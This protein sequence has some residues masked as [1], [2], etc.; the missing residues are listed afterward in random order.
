MRYRTLTFVAAVAAALSLLPGQ[1]IAQSLNAKPAKTATEAWTAPRTV[2]GRP[3]PVSYT[4]LDVY[5][6][7]T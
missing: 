6:R 1:A 5:K 4:H 7:Q 3:D 2:D